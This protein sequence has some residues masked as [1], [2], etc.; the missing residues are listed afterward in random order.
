MK[1]DDTRENFEWLV[2]LLDMKGTDI[3][4][5]IV[6]FRRVEHMSVVFKH[7]INTLGRKAYVSYKEDGPN[8]DRNKLIGMFHMKSKKISNDQELIQSD[9]ISCPQN[10]KGNY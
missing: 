6:F 8:D 5:I 9:P 10:Q 1:S 3:P 2:K 7:V 4:R